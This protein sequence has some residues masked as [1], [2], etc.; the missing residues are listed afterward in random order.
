MAHSLND[1]A[2]RVLTGGAS[3]PKVTGFM[4]LNVSVPP[5]PSHILAM[6]LPHQIVDTP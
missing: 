3:H 5:R 1:H 4:L 6:F 2:S